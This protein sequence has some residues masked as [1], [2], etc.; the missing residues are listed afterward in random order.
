MAAPQKTIV[1]STAITSTSQHKR[2]FSEK[3]RRFN[4]NLTKMLALVKGSKV[5]NYGNPVYQK[6]LIEKK[7]ATRLDPEWATYTA[8]EQV[9]TASAAGSAT[10]FKVADNS[11]FAADDTVVNM[12]TSEVAIVSSLNVDG[13]TVNVTAVGGTWSCSKDHSILLL[14]PSYE[15][16]SSRYGVRTRELD[17]HKTYLTIARTAISLAET[18]LK[19]PQYTDE[20]MLERYSTDEM[21]AY[22]RKMEGN[23]WFSKQATSTTTSVTIDGTAYPLYTMQGM[24]A[25]AGAAIN[26]NGSFNW[27]TINTVLYP[28]LPK[29]LMADEVIYLTCGRKVAAAMNMWA[30]NKYMRLS[31]DKSPSFGHIPERYL[32]GNGVEVEIQVHDLFESGA[33]A[34]KAIIWQSSDLVYR[35]MEG[36]DVK[37][38]ENIQLPSTMGVTNEIRGVFG[39]QSISNG[40]NIK[41]LSNLLPSL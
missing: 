16:G 1:T 10:T 28:I 14:L 33:W 36:L 23:F 20:G 40:A 2:D 24:N 37:V 25:Y 3:I 18:V 11:F 5:D 8:V 27:E 41:V 30:Q 6:G 32:I 26:M 22:L 39:L 19:T 21:L 4:P 7:K 31:T 35:F 9:Y 13:V 15:E 17:V 29:T 38:K 34:N 12:D